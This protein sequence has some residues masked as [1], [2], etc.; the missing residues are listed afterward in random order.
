MPQTET[1]FTKAADKAAFLRF[2]R[3]TIFTFVVLARGRGSAGREAAAV[4]TIGGRG[5]L[6][7]MEL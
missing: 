3:F 6:D 5:M 4:M 1:A 2:P 7:I